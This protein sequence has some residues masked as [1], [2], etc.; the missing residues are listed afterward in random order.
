MPLY[1][2][3][4]HNYT[5]LKTKPPYSIIKRPA[6]LFHHL[7]GTLVLH[8]MRRTFRTRLRARRHAP[9][10]STVARQRGNHSNN[11]LSHHL[12]STLTS[13]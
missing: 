9:L 12:V 3:S 8:D 1:V 6:A 2:L 7:V 11:E 13:H 4:T 5:S 10:N